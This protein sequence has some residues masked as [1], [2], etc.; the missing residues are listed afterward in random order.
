MSTGRKLAIVVEPALVDRICD[1]LRQGCSVRTT[2]ECA[3]L[4]QSCFFNYMRRGNPDETDHDSRFLEFT[5]RVTRARG[6]GNAKPVTDL[7][8]PDA[9]AYV[10]TQNDK[11]GA[12]FERDICANTKNVVKRCKIPGQY[13][14]LNDWLKAGAT[15]DDL[16]EALASAEPIERTTAESDESLPVIEDAATAIS[17]PIVLP[18]DVIAGILHVG[19]KAVIGGTSK[20]NKTWVLSDTAISVATGTEWL[21]KFQ[22]TKGR[23]LYV[24]LELPGP[25]F[26]YRIKTICDERQLKLESGLLNAWNLRGY[27]MDLPKLLPGIPAGAYTLIVIDPI[28]KLLHRRDE[29]KAGDIADLMNGLEMLAVRTGAAVAFGAHYSKGNQSQKESID[30]I[31][32]SGVF[33]RD[34]DTI[35]NFTKHEEEDC[36]TVEMTLRNHAPVKPFVVRWTYPLFVTDG[37]LDPERLRQAG[38]KPSESLLSEKFLELLAEPLSTVDWQK[39]A[40]AELGASP[41]TFY[42]RKTELED[43]G[44][45]AKQDKKWVLLSQ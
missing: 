1:L 11:A 43:A 7:L 17:L 35:I 28:Y 10:W 41:A 30:R 40:A 29:N 31:G 22:T 21:G 13:K 18:D 4:S 44:K 14:D 15:T 5:E 33:A 12:K 3:G 42:R 38:C 36:F 23:V 9:T 26:W 32:G 24:N 19:G 45:I 39:L 2:C 16:V 8:T 20:S 25:Y 6:A 37:V 27:A 34:P